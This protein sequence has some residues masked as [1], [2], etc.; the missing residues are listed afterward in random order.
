MPN[1][2]KFSVGI[3]ASLLLAGCASTN[4]P[5]SNPP[6]KLTNVSPEILAQ[7]RTKLPSWYEPVTPFKIIG[8]DTQA[9][10]YVGTKGLGMYFM[11]TKDGH[12]V[13]DG[14]MPDQGQYVADQIRKLGFDPKDIKILLNSHAHMDHSG[15]LAELKHISGAQLFASQG[16]QSALESGLYLG[17]EDR[18]EFNAPPIK[19]DRVIQDGETISLG[20]VTLTA[21]LTPGHSQGCTSWT[22]KQ[23]IAERMLEIVFFCSATVAANRLFP[24][25]YPGIVDDYR[26]TFTKMRDWRPDI[27]LANHPAFIGL[28]GKREKQ[29]SG[30]AMAFVDPTEFPQAMAKL[31]AAFEKALIRQSAIMEE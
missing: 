23:P 1:R 28:L 15:G 25:Q 4:L 17:Y 27:F 30:D 24:E 14:G 26:A 5:S 7:Y 20:G 29:L 13:L 21:R 31:E 19:V 9:V 16:D 3:L 11:P 6:F 8:N 10:Y 12:I 18:N 22:M 2:T